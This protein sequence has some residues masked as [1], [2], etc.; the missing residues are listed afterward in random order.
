M[1]VLKKRKEILSLLR[2]N[3][4][5]TDPVDVVEGKILR[6]VIF[7]E[8]VNDVDGVLILRDGSSIPVVYNY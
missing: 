4:I 7:E 5:S 8:P 3:I 6:L 2:D 1:L